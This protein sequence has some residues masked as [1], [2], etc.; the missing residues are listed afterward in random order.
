MI[1]TFQ[2]VLGAAPKRLSDVYGDGAGVVNAVKD[3]P[4]NS[5]SLQAEAADLYIGGDNSVSTTAYG[6]KVA[7]GSSTTISGVHH[8]SDLWAVGAGATVHIVGVPT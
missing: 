1:R 8:L 3:V 6:V 7:T 5:L 2:L 4:F